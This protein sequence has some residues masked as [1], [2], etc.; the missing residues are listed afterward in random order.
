MIIA[1]DA[2][3]WNRRVSTSA[4]FHFSVV[5]GAILTDYLS[6]RCTA[7][8]LYL[9]SGVGSA[10]PN[11]GTDVAKISRSAAGKWVW[12]SLPP[13]PQDGYRWLGSS[14]VIGDY[15]YA[16]VGLST[17]PLANGGTGNTSYTNSTYRLKLSTATSDASVAW[18]RV[19]DFPSSKGSRVPGGLAASGGLDGPNDA[20]VN[21]S[22]YI[23]GGGTDSWGEGAQAKAFA[24]LYALDLPVPIVLDGTAGLR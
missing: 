20:V 2:R 11:N 17:R 12:E 14:G 23:I 24:A 8:A 15:L 18:E 10:T 1:L 13:L 6:S 3:P 4:V 5:Y 9:V 22:L 19:A 16:A 21:G 7:D